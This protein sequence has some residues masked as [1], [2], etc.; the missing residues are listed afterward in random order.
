MI[1]HFPVI[2]VLGALLVFGYGLVRKNDEVKLLGLGSFVLVGLSTIAVYFTGGAA[3]EVVKNLP[4]VTESYIG[5]HE[6]LALLAFVLMELLGVVALG[7]LFLFRKSGAL[8][9]WYT[10]LVLAIALAGAGVVSLTANLGG[11]IRHT[12][13][14]DTT[15]GPVV[16]SN[17]VPQGHKK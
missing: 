2:G 10:A 4:G 11:Q 16:P 9:K 12:E 1:N 15:G 5:T 7:G 17:Q 6:E 13:I 3:E 14:R 8:P